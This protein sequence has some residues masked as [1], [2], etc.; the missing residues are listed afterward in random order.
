MNTVVDFLAAYGPLALLLMGA[1]V[2]IDPPKPKGRGHKIWFAVF[3][4]VGGSVSW[5]SYQQS[6]DA[7]KLS[8]E[9]NAR[10]SDTNRLVHKIAS[11]LDLPSTATLKD[12]SKKIEKL[13]PHIYRVPA[14]TTYNV[15]TENCTINVENGTPSVQT[16]IYLPKDPFQGQVVTVRNMQNDQSARN[17]EIWENGHKIGHEE[18]VYII[19]ESDAG[20]AGYLTMTFDVDQWSAAGEP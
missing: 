3:I 11:N 1:W 19:T 17:I 7:H 8:Q 10:N 9:S 18:R 5:A 20:G 2:S 13:S 14:G 6:R 16:E 12:I 15:S 4:I